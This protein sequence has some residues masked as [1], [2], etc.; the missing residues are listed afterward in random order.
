MLQRSPAKLDL[1][2]LIRHHSHANMYTLYPA[3]FLS[4]PS[5]SPACSR[6]PVSLCP[7]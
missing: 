6:S 2:L 1:I 7:F 4:I 3:Y 5:R